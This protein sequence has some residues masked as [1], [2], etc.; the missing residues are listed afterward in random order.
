MYA[1]FGVR[2][3]KLYASGEV[4]IRIGIIRC[5]ALKCRVR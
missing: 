2:M 3:P 1:G 5:E 4:I